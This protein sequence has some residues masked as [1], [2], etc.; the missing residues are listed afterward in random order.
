MAI[1]H[2]ARI[3]TDSQDI[4]N[5]AL[6]VEQAGFKIDAYFEDVGVSGTLPAMKRDGFSR[7][8][9]QLKAGDTVITVEISRIGRSTID[10]LEIVDVLTKLGVKLRVLN[11][12]GVDLTSP[13]GKMLLTVMAACAQFER[14]LLIERTHAGLSRAKASGK[15]LGSKFKVSFENLEWAA[16]MIAD[17]VPHIDIANKLGVSSATLSALKKNWMCSNE[18]MEEYKQRYEAQQK[19]INKGE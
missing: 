11:L 16:E 1:F 19:Q 5:Q 2:Y 4:S 7:M 13:M 9:S 10:V 3:S 18:K 6:Q 17:K 8:M 15:V 12:D 14:D